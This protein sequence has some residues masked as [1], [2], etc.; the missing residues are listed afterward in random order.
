ML[1][2]AESVILLVNAQNFENEDEPYV[3]GKGLVGASGCVTHF[4]DI[5]KHVQ[6]LSLVV[7]KEDLRKYSPHLVPKQVNSGFDIAGVH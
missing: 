4:L 3:A 7:G 5:E 2:N 6:S 1:E